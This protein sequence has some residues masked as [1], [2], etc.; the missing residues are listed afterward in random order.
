M[1]RDARCRVTTNLTAASSA[2]VN[3]VERLC[4][5]DLGEAD[6]EHSTISSTRRWRRF[7]GR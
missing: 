1:A 7:K 3:A 4:D 5:R 2:V 6:R